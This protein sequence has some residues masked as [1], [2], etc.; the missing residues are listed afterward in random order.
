MVQ[1]TDAPPPDGSTPP[2]KLTAWRSAMLII[3]PAAAGMAA[4]SL[5]AVARHYGVPTLLAVLSSAVFDG[6]A[7]ACA[8]LAS[9]AIRAGRSAAA[10]IAAALGLA[11]V[12]VYLN[13]VHAE[14][15][16]GGHPAEVLYAT[17]TIGLIIVSVLSWS[18]ARS[19]A[20][21]ARGESPM[22]LPAYGM[23]G[24]LLA[25]DEATAALKQ[26]AITH[27]TS[28]ASPAHQPASRRRTAHAVLIEKFAAM[29]PAE[30]ITVA[31]ES[32]PHL[33]HAEL[34]ELLGS[35]G[36]TVSALDVALI[37]SLAATPTVTLDRVHPDPTALP[38]HGAKPAIGAR[39]QPAA[40]ANAPQVSDLTK[41]DAIIAMAQHFGGLDTD[42]ATIV[43]ALALQGQGTDT[44]YV[45][46]RLSLARKAEQAAAQA[47]TTKAAEEKAAHE[48]RYGTGGII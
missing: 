28:G 33:N 45:R 6:I 44:A 39:M 35:Y 15:T 47:A 10:P 17:P 31:A 26:R 46:H 30:V 40:F 4:W 27:V 42:A 38:Q 36:T 24:W 7:I 18:A 8:Y 2:R 29:D 32:H 34:A 21:E 12:S 43:Q 20:R 11:A 37:L 5:Y 14:L 22:R 1:R 9:E 19:A 41:A 48:R 13:V 25:R 3:R 23:W 16:G